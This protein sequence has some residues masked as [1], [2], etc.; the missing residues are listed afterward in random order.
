VKALFLL[1]RNCVDEVVEMNV[2]LVNAEKCAKVVSIGKYQQDF[3]ALLNLS[4]AEQN[5]S[6]S[7]QV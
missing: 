3:L 1:L 2:K 6:S 4:K 7:Q 5:T